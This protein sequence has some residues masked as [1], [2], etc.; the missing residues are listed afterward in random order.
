[1]YENAPGEGGIAQTIRAVRH[2]PRSRWSAA[3]SASRGG[4]NQDKGEE[5]LP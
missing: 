4:C 5:T 2:S 1:M 3:C